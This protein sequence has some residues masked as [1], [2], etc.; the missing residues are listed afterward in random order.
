MGR[1]DAQK[2]IDSA[3]F[4][5]SEAAIQKAEIDLKFKDPDANF[6]MHIAAGAARSLAARHSAA[7]AAAPVA[8]EKVAGP[9]S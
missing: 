9:L 1:L 3:M 8:S 6:M 2:A 4:Q 5:R 7:K